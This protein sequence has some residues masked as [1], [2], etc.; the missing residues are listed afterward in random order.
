MDQ[1]IFIS[2]YIS[3]KADLESLLEE[4]ANYISQ[5]HYKN[6]I[7]AGD[8]NARSIRWNDRI[9]NK[10]GKLVE[11][12]ADQLELRLINEGGTPTC[13]RTQGESVIDLT[14]ST[15]GLINKI[16]NWQVLEEHETYSDHHY[17]IFEL[18]LHAYDDYQNN[19]TSSLPRWSFRK[20][21]T[22]K[23]IAAVEL[24]SQICSENITPK[25]PNECALW[26]KENITEACD[27]STPRYKRFGRT[28]TYWWS[29]QIAKLRS[30]CNKNRRM[31][32]KT[33]KKAGKLHA[34]LS[35]KERNQL[36]AIESARKDLRTAKNM[37]VWKIRRSKIL[38]WRQ[39]I[40]TLDKDPW[41]RPYKIVLN[42]LKKYSPSLTETLELDQ[43]NNILDNLFPDNPGIDERPALEGPTDWNENLCVD[44]VE[45]SKAIKGK[46]F[47]NVAPGP[48]GLQKCVWFKIPKS[49]LLKILEIFNKCLAKGS[50]PETWKIAK[51]ILIPKTN[52]SGEKAKYR[53]IC[54][55]DEI[56]KIFERV[57]VTRL[58]KHIITNTCAQLS[59]HQFGFRT[60]HSTTDA[61]FAVKKFTD[62]AFAEDKC[63]VAVALDIENA[64]NSLPWASIILELER[65]NFPKY[66]VKIISSYLSNRQ[67]L[68]RL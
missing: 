46:K 9:T 66:L 22:E 10:R 51:L 52:K 43:I 48:D 42:K 28:Q 61:L 64:F 47:G 32:T 27:Y 59:K 24:K 2:V 65:K 33:K 45:L 68:Y 4:I 49:F 53:P 37:L 14:W 21:D 58:N 15:P 34:E 29:D 57:I 35:E 50:Y 44:S 60:G 20:M 31:L 18:K 12:W 26:L 11:A 63:V 40:A 36:P 55:L 17:V 67:I 54:L 56:G 38:A 19:A 25:S 5:L 8:F 39:L 23:F 30:V 7:I 62:L 3:P 13:S 41:G 6:I 16:H 1:L